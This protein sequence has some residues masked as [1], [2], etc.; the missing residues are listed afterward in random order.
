VL[1]QQLVPFTKYSGCGNDFILIDNSASFLSIACPTAVVRLCHRQFGVGG[2]GLVLLE[3]SDIADF[4][5]RIYNAD[6]TEAEMCGNGIRCLAHFIH[7][8]NPNVHTFKIETM[9]KLV[10]VNIEDDNINVE[11]PLPTEIKDNLDIIVNDKTWTG[12]FLNTGVPHFVL[13]VDDLEADDLFLQAPFI[14]SHSEFCPRG[15]NV[16]FAK[17]L[18]DKTIA[19]RTYERGVEKETLAC[20]T[21]AAAV[22]WTAARLFNLPSPI[23]I[24]PRSQESLQI[25][26]DGLP[27]APSKIKMKGPANKIFQGEIALGSLGF[28]LK[29]SPLFR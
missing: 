5:M 10:S 2:D 20:G 6:G 26:Y 1:S 8:R 27:P 13:F 16:D 22:A 11:M 19:V 9:H 7:E 28:Q 4:R 21:G 15:T 17:V 3:K 14:R 18:N 24:Y 25:T 12:H 29:S 23:T